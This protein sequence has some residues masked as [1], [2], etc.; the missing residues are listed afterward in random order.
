[1]TSPVWESLG[2]RHGYSA[3]DWTCNWVI[4][5]EMM[6]GEGEVP[7]HHLPRPYSW[8]CLSPQG[9]I[10]QE[11]AFCF[12]R[13]PCKALRSR[14][15]GGDDEAWT[16][17]RTLCLV[18][19]KSLGQIGDRTA[20]RSSLFSFWIFSNIE[21]QWGKVKR[22]F[23]KTNQKLTFLFYLLVSNFQL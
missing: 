16:D 7:P 18:K 10:R 2:E 5:Q 22:A 13:P 3:F 11:E 14:V 12:F 19:S 8:A 6:L 1:M 17:K 20:A 9:K 21:K 4:P 23:K 15:S